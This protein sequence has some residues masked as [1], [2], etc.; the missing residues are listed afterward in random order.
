MKIRVEYY[1]LNEIIVQ[2]ERNIYSIEK[3][4]SSDIIF[5]YPDN[6]LQVTSTSLTSRKGN[7]YIGDNELEDY[8]NGLS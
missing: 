8:N 3:L 1:R 2:N 4:S 6:R 5:S 7:K